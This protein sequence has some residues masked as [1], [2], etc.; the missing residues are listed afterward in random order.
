MSERVEKGGLMLREK[1]E[2]FA[3]KI[4]NAGTGKQLKSKIKKK[5]LE[6]DYSNIIFRNRLRIELKTEA[7][8]VPSCM[9]YPTA[10][11]KPH[12]LS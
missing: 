10:L 2:Q 9:M 4:L 5:T 8:T 6:L 12:C 1:R 7:T 11:V 3:T